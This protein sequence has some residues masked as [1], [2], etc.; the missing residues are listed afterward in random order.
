MPETSEPVTYRP[1]VAWI[2][3][4]AAMTRCLCYQA[5]CLVQDEAQV[6]NRRLVKG[7]AVS[8]DPRDGV[9]EAQACRTERL[10]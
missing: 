4:R 10:P 5:E 2:L 6:S 1:S 3:R 9:Y 7:R 8:A